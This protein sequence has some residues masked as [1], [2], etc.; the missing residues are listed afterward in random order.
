[1]CDR[2]SRFRCPA[3]SFWWGLVGLYLA[4][5]AA[6]FL[7]FHN[8]LSGHPTLVNALVSVAL[9]TATAAYTL[10]ANRQYHELVLARGAGIRPY[11]VV[12]WVH[13]ESEGDATGSG[14]QVRVSTKNVGPGPALSVRGKLLHKDLQFEFVLARDGWANDLPENHPLNVVPDPVRGVTLVFRASAGAPTDKNLEN[15]TLWLGCRDLQDQ[16]WGFDFPVRLGGV[17]NSQPPGHTQL[18]IAVDDQ[19]EDV[20]RIPGPRILMR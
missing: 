2:L 9:F 16:W 12:E 13:V 4:F 11:L 20:R 7:V 17:T 15:A 14:L 3:E 18:T 19:S 10:V 8:W 1:M 5:V 6:V